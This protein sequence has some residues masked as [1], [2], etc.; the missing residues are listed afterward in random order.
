M[1]R[2]AHDPDDW[3]DQYVE[4]SLLEGVLSANRWSCYF[5]VLDPETGCIRFREFTK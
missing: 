3:T 4:F 5:V 2:R 1:A